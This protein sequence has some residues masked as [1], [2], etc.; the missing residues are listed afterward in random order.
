MILSAN[1]VVQGTRSLLTSHLEARQTKDGLELV[2]TTG[3]LIDPKGMFLKS[4]TPI[5]QGK[6]G[7]DYV[8]IGNDAEGQHQ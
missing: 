3:D 7:Q 1:R 4:Q 8:F 2:N 6:D 5:A